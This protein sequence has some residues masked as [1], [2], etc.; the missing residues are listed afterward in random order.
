MT[1]PT[2]RTTRYRYDRAGNLDLL[3]DPAGRTTTLAYDFADQLKAVNYSDAATPDVSFTYDQLG[4][5]ETMTDGTGTQIYTWDSL[6]RLET[7]TNGRSRI[8]GYH[9]DLAG[10]LEAIDYDATRSVTRGYDGAGQ[11]DFVRDWQSN[12]TTFD[13]DA[14]ANLEFQNYANGTQAEFDYDNAEQLV[15]ITHRRGATTLVDLDYTRDGEGLLATENA[16]PFGYDALDRLKSAPGVGYS[17]DNGDNLATVAASAAPTTTF[18][19]NAAHELTNANIGGLDFVYLYDSNGN[20]TAKLAPHDDPVAD[21][22]ERSYG[23]DQA[24]RLVSYNSGTYRYSYDGDGL[25]T[26]KTTGTT[27]NGFTWN[28][29]EGLPQLVEGEGATSYITGAGGLPLAQVSPSGTVQYFHADQLGSTRALTDAS[30]AVVATFAYDPYGNRTTTTGPA[31]TAFG[32]AG[33][34]TDAES[35]LHYLRQRY[36]D[37]ATGQFLTR[38]PIE[39]VTG[40]PY[41]YAWN[42]PTNFVDPSGFGG[43]RPGVGR[44]PGEAPALGPLPGPGPLTS[45]PRSPMPIPLPSTGVGDGSRNTSEGP[46]RTGSIPTRQECI[47]LKNEAGQILGGAHNPARRQRYNEWKRAHAKEIDLCRKLYGIVMPRPRKHS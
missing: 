46:Q 26:N 39:E 47:D 30:G 38:D 13:Y 25:R 33:S 22:E 4:R 40:Q 37:P 17:Y 19:H 41:A 23:Y 16:Q 29:A 43:E 28:V 20:R 32:Y 34:Y 5:R 45:P 8:L 15:G 1:D 27:V 36:Y 35:G 21:A 6:G 11:L 7:H 14:N 24:N 9:H 10:R 31:T 42:S 12:T 18:T 3:T 44:G 2:S